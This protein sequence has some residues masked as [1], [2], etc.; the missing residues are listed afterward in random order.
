M[1]TRVTGLAI[2]VLALLGADSAVAGLCP[3]LPSEGPCGPLEVDNPTLRER[4]VDG[5]GAPDNVGSAGGFC[6]GGDSPAQCGPTPH[7]EGKLE[8]IVVDPGT[9]TVTCTTTHWWE[10]IW[11]MDAGC[12]QCLAAGVG[13]V[14]LPAGTTQQTWLSVISTS[15]NSDICACG[16]NVTCTFSK[17]VECSDGADG[18]G[19]GLIDTA[20]PD[21]AGG[22]DPCSPSEGGGNGGYVDLE[23]NDCPT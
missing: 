4:D 3:P 21:C 7:E 2:I 16:G 10:E 14:T 13:S 6:G 8:L 9:Q 18:D 1:M 5:N 20:D 19:D 22:G 23:L 11:I 15:D 12:G 17:E